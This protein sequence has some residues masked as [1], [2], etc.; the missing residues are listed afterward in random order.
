MMNRFSPMTLARWTAALLTVSALLF[1]LA[2][3]LE[4]G[5]ESAGGAAHVEAGE[6]SAATEA[7]GAAEGTAPVA[8]SEAGEAAEG[9]GQQREMLL[10]I[11]LE[12]PW[13]VWGFVAASLILAA[14]VLRLWPPAFLLTILLA[15]AAALLDVREVFS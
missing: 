1:A 12:N 5:G 2:V 10:G 6:G 14:V 9:G 8:H 11:N 13:L 3:L 15:G 7:G 4:H